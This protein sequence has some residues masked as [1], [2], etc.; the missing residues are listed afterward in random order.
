[1]GSQRL[2]LIAGGG[3]LPLEVAAG[4][5]RAGR[6]V[7][8][9]GFHGHT[10]A[11]LEG[12]VESVCWLHPGQVDR[13]V[14]AL[15]GAGA[16]EAVMVGKLP[17]TVL[18]DRPERLE[19]DASAA[20]LIR[21]LPDWR[22]DSILGLVAEHL[23][24]RGIEL[25][26]QLDF[27]PQLIVA[28]GALGSVKPTASAEAD[29]RFGWLIAKAIAGL[30]IGQT[31]VVKD[32]AVLA[33]EAIEGTDQT[34]RRAGTL[35]AEACVVKVAKPNQDPRF[36]LPTIGPD[37]AIALIDARVSTLAFEASQTVVLQREELVEIADRHGLALLGVAVDRQ[38]G[39]IW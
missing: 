23:G 3:R 29:I 18:F 35:A 28:S 17:K 37:T 34:I 24:S 12:G 20:A 32:G 33:V 36:D 31:V 2:G 30:D 22:D 8:A 15:L 39:P 21:S 11:A 1:M 7:V 13:A 6:P 25:L 26:G 16:R 10:D 14:D 38:R 9:I 19:L 27:V 5:R 4:A